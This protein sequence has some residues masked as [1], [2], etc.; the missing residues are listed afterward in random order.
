[1][2]EIRNETRARLASPGMWGWEGSANDHMRY[3]KK[4]AGR[5][6]RRKCDCGCGGRATHFGLANG[7]GLTSGCEWSIRRWVRAPDAGD[8]ERWERYDAAQMAK[9]NGA[10]RC[11]VDGCSTPPVRRP[12]GRTL[13]SVRK[14]LREGA[15]WTCDKSGDFC[16]EHAAPMRRWVRDGYGGTA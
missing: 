14:A 12:A 15:G 7:L 5:G 10:V 1:M 8:Q 6:G 2:S 13:A 3:A 9:P 4:I 16:P 11:A